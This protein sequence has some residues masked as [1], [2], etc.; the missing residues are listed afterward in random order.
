M[1]FTF[2]VEIPKDIT[3]RMEEEYESVISI[4]NE[5]RIGKTKII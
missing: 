2:K 1:T 5:T 4:K 3:N